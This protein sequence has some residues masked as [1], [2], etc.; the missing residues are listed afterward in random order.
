MILESGTG[1]TPTHTVTVLAGMMKQ[2]LCNF[3]LNGCKNRAE[4][5]AGCSG[6]NMRQDTD[7]KLI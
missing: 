5:T 4:G 6:V 7:N 1:E 3:T 2:A